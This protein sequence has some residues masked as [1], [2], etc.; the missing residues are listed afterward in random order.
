MA[1]IGDMA[2]PADK[3]SKN[4]TISLMC[5]GFI[6]SRYAMVI[7]PK[8]ISLFAVNFFVGCTGLVQFVRIYMYEQSLE[9]QKKEQ[10]AIENKTD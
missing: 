10:K 1:G 9:A 4:Q 7:I 8:N 3:L 2:R 5:T 6:W